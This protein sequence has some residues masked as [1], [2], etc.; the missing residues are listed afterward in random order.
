MTCIPNADSI[1]DFIVGRLAELGIPD[2]G[3]CSEIVL[4]NDG[5]FLGRRFE[6]E[7]VQAVW[8]SEADEVKFYSADGKFLQADRLGDSNRDK[9]AA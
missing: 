7:T 3:P 4:I 6:F 9:E 2:P 8:F 1:R 5:F